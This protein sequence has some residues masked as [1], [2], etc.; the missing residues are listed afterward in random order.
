M[1]NFVTFGEM[2]WPTG[3]A[4]DEDGFVYVCEHCSVANK[5]SVF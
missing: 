2:K 4:V 5:I 1:L 3:I